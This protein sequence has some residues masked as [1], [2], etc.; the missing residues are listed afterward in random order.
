MNILVVVN[1]PIDWPLKIQGVNV[2]SAWVYLTDPQYME[3]NSTRVFNLCRS[4]RYQSVGYYVSL[5]AAARGHKPI[6]SVT[7][8]QDVKSL[9]IIRAVSDDLD[10][11]MQ[12][13]LA[14]I[15][16]NAFTLSIYFGHNMAKRYERLSLELFNLFQAPFL[17]AHF[18]REEDRWQLQSI[19][20]IAASE[21]PESHIKFVVDVATGFFS[22]RRA[23]IARKAPPRY[24][25]AILCNQ[26]EGNKP[27]NDGALERFEK[28]AEKLGI[29]VEMI[30]RDDF[31]RLAEFDA[32]F[33]RETTSVMHHTYRFAR[34]A[35]AEGLV[36][37]DDSKSILRCTNKVYLAELLDRYD[38][39]TPKTII[40]HKDN[41]D[42]IIPELGLPCVLKQPDSS[43]SQGVV[44]V[45]NET[46]LQ[47]EV[48]RLLDKSDLMIAQEFISTP[49]DW[50][51][52]VLD[53]RPLYACKYYMARRHWQIIQR[54][55]EGES[56]FGRVE[57]LPVEL[58]PRQVVRTAV[59]AA[60]LI[61]DGLYG[62]DLK[63]VERQCYVIEVNDNPS[64][65][66]GFEDDVLKDELYFRI[67]E[68]FLR[69]IEQTK[70][71]WARS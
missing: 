15:Q 5:L 47:Q 36:V 27:S 61:G 56:N 23:R 52:G 33:I 48:S 21:I 6:P 42:R 60:N 12:E 7:T 4:Y 38:I 10:E 31:A 63:Q 11:T 29:E 51:I 50:R 57:T 30:D 25:M 41:V 2:V 49:F 28:A 54:T 32:L 59:K 44:K 19:R 35:E 55:G 1:N 22:G 68:V 58:A 9:T 40:V 46:Q 20:P 34:R 45:E 17:R 16:S 69:R 26:E 39:R 71:A 64:I 65:D 37:I 18:V 43:F 14:T 13:S 8:I 53:K 3:M 70:F 24:T 67:M 62:V 66:A